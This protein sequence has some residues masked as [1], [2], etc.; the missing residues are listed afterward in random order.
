MGECLK[1]L[2]VPA[3]RKL[4]RYRDGDYLYSFQLQKLQDYSPELKTVRSKSL[5]F[6][7]RF[8]TRLA[9]TLGRRRIHLPV[10]RKWAWK[11]SEFYRMPSA[12]PEIERADGIL[13]YE[14]YPVNADRPVI[15][16]AGAL[17]IEKMRRRGSPEREIQEEMDFKRE[18]N[19]KAA[20]TVLTTYSKKRL[21]D[22]AVRPSKPTQVI[23]FLQPIEPI[24]ADD[25][26]AKWRTVPP[27]KLLFIG[28][29][30]KRKGLP[31]ALEAYKI[32]Q[33]RY[34]G[35]VTMHVVSTL[36]DGFVE[37]PE[38]PGLV[39]EPRVSHARAIGMM[40]TSHY[41]LMPSEFEEYGWVYIE[42]MA[43][44]TIPLAADSATQRELLD[45]GRAGWLVTRNAEAIV[46]A[47][48]SGIEAPDSARALAYR[49]LEHWRT[50]YAPE[51]IAKQ[52]AALAHSSLG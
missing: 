33:R 34:P 6:D 14:R 4:D 22:E 29:A 32:L 13:A 50:R 46:E 31:L 23:P 9:L 20:A 45:E 11:L 5:L 28:R 48:A 19:A 35:K 40:A 44:G 38:L 36:Q 37:I 12:G 18:A 17:D 30:A 47:V 52:F 42:A 3:P 16:I 15:W 1:T 8:Y 39:H 43:Q 49:A 24:V 27:I 25:F 26:V 10:P 2:Y 21:F 51:I 41:L 7:L